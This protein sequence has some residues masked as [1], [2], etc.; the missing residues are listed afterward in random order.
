MRHP[1]S[2]LLLALPVAA[3]SGG[4]V[5]E[6]VVASHLRPCVGVTYGLCLQVTDVDDG[7]LDLFYEGIEGFDF[8]WG[9]EVTLRYQVEDVD[10]PPADGSSLRYVLDD[11]M[12]AREEL[13]GAPFTATFNPGVIGEAWFAADVPGVVSMVGTRVSCEQP[14]CDA[15]VAAGT[16]VGPSFR[17]SFEHTGALVP[18]RATALESIP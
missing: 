14:L 6:G 12:S 10:D 8:R 5:R 9:V 13:P 16:D 17:V 3:C 15:L 7:E 1:C 2:L 18:L 11:V 4:E